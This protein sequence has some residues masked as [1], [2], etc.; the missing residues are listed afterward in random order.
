VSEVDFLKLGFTLMGNGELRAPNNCRL[1]LTRDG[2]FYEV[3]LMLRT[4]D[5]L[6]CVVPA[7]GLKLMREQRS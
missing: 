1:V 5:T 4:G 6:L 2:D 7:R 3:K